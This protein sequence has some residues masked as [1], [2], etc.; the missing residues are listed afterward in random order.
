MMTVGKPPPDS[1]DDQ[2][3]DMS[4][5]LDCDPLALAAGIDEDIGEACQ[6]L[7]AGEVHQSEG[8]AGEGN[9]IIG[10]RVDTPNG[11]RMIRARCGVV[12]AA[13]GF[14]HDNGRKRALFAHAPS[15]AE[16]HSA[17]PSTNTDDGIALGEA[18]GA[19]MMARTPV[20]RRSFVP[21]TTPCVSFPAASAPSPDSRSTRIHA[22][23][24]RK[25]RRPTEPRSR[26]FSRSATMRRA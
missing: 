1:S 5:D 8:G 20:S 19:T 12:L 26:D 9:S 21:P 4:F 2:N 11:S 13:G 3:R 18:V 6:L 14:P 10:A 23:S 25:P 16:H 15:G 7:R 24:T 22:C 17:A